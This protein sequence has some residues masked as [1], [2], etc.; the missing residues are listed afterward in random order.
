VAGCTRIWYRSF[1]VW[2][3]K[4]P[5]ALWDFARFRRMPCW[6]FSSADLA[7]AMHFS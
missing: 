7:K 1:R 3:W 4:S 2:Y 6:L 5:E